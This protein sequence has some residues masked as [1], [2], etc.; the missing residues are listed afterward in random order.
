MAT[1]VLST[2]GTVLGGPIGGAIGALVGQSFDQQ[3][4]G[5][6]TRGPRLGDLS[7]Q[8]SSYGTQ[9]PRIYG[10][11]R[12][13]GSVIWAT[14]LTESEQTTGAKGQPDVTYS[15]S[16]SLAVALSSRV[17]GSIGRIWADGQLLRGAEGDFKVPTTFRFYP[18]SEG[19]DI[20]PLIASVEGI[21]NTPA[22]R[23]LA[24]AVFEDLELAAFG[25]R[26]PF[27]TFEVI[28]DQ[29]PV[30]IG[31]IL[32]DASTGMITSD[33]E[34]TLSGY[35]AYG[36][37]VAAAL[38]PL[39]EAFDVPL[40]DDGSRV[41]A[42]T[43]D[44][45]T[46]IEVDELGCAPDGERAAPVQ[47]EQRAART[48]PSTL[49]LTYYDQ[50]RDYQTGEARSDAGDMS[51][52][53]VQQELPA[54]LDAAAAKG[55]VQQMLARQWAARDRLTLRLPPGRLTLEPGALMVSPAAPGGWRVD[56]CTIDG[57]V[58]IAELTPYWRP[59]VEVA[60]QPGRIVATADMVAAPTSLA[61][62]DVPDVTESSSGPALL[63][64]A[65]S[66]AKNWAA[67]ALVVSGGGQS[68]TA[69]TAL[70]RSVL[71]RTLTALPGAAPFLIDAVNRVD[72]ELV[73]PEQWLTSCDDDALASGRNFAVV[74]SEL[75]QFADVAPL[76]SGRFR[77][78]RFL[79]SRA[80]TEWAVDSHAAG[81][82][83]CLLDRASLRAM[84]LPAQVRGAT[85]QAVDRS[86]ASASAGFQA[87]SVRPLSPVKLS[88]SFDAA[89]ALS[90]SWT[91]RSRAGLSWVDEVDAPLGETGE[92]YRVTI[93]GPGQS[94]EFSCEQ[95]R[96][97]IAA[98]ELAGLGSVLIE[99]RQAGDWAASRPAQITVDLP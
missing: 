74:G 73:D 67:R 3:M 96:L 32:N 34:D 17:V 45:P 80:G 56:T 51:S 86:G 77:L 2:V 92:L 20:D 68:M 46:S 22:Y 70:R 52:N 40:F 99:V 76:G 43:S 24:L 94:V 89:G 87:N 64:A 90:V 1:L 18:G 26:I 97:S 31:A 9:V 39:V 48:A 81:E 84:A 60:A 63:V 15:Y 65:S 30:S 69:R 16:V 38:Q 91:R 47:R 54:V 75:I 72:V 41:R 12:V 21:A 98:S 29:T 49:R 27:M 53:E 23:G 14:D 5:P 10:A 7:V 36:H 88:A 28:A 78:S 4:L 62:L 93:S 82:T 66:A 11:M 61:L 59:N 42:P 25:N 35:A 13:A 58:T 37:S 57:F 83:F 79:R 71:G 85:V 95:P 44:G 55:L 6:A 50:A 33:C 8:T 19:Q